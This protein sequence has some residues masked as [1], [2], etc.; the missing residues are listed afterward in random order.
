[1]ANTTITQLPVAISL[2]GSEK[3]EIVQNGTSKQATTLQVGTL[4][5]YLP[6]P[7]NELLG[8]VSGGTA[9]A[10]GVTLTEFLDAT[11]SSTQGSI[12]YRDATGWTALG[13]GTSGFVL[14]T[15][16]PA[17]NPS[18][19]SVGVGS[20]TSISAGTNITASPDPITSI[21]TISVVASPSF[22]DVTITNDLTFNTAGSRI[23]GDF[24]NATFSDRL[25]FQTT[26]ANSTTGIYAL[27]SGSATAASWQATNA[28]DP[29]NASKILIATNASVDVQL[30]SGKNGSGSYL[31]LAFYTNNT[32]R[33]V[34]NTAGAFGIGP[35]ASADYGLSGQAFISG[36]VAAQPT[37]G[38]LSVGGGG[39]G[40]TTF[41][42][43]GVIYGNLTG[44]L[45]VTAA[46]TTGQFLVGNTGAAPT[47]SSTLPSSLAV[48]DLSFGTTGLTPS[49][50]TTGSITVAGTLV[51]ANGGTGQ[52]SYAV[53]DILYAATSSTLAK[54]ADVAVG[55]VLVSGGVGVA[56]AWS[57]APN[58][59]GTL[60]ANY[61]IA[62][63][64]TSGTR[65]QGAFAYG[66][67][68]YSDT[69]ILASF[70][71]SVDSY[72]EIIIQ[73][74]N[75]GTSASTNFIVA[76]DL[77]TS[78]TYFGEFGMNSSNFSGTGS[79]G[80]PNNIYLAATSADLVLATVTANAIRFA[81]N[82]GATD[83]MSINSSSVTNIQS[84]TLS[85][86]LGPTYGG[87]GLSSYTVGDLIYASASNTL[88]KLAD[89]AVGSV[90]VSG[91]IATA[92]S[93][94]SS[95]TISTSVTTPVIIGGTAAGSTLTLQSTSGVGTTDQVIID[96]GNNGSVTAATFASTGAFLTM[97][98]GTTAIAPLKL[99][100]GTN[101]TT[102]AA[103][104]VE[105]DGTNYYA[106]ATTVAGRGII[107][108]IQHFKL[109]ASGSAIG[110]AIAD[111]FGTG[112][113]TSLETNSYY[114]L[115]ADLFFTKTTAGTVT[116]TLTFSNAPQSASAYYVGTPVGGVGTVGNAVT[117]A[118]IN[119]TS[120]AV[121]MPATGSLTTAVNH[122]YKIKA[123][124]RANA[125][126]GGTL[127]VRITSSAGT[128]TPLILSN[129]KVTK[130]PATNTG[131]FA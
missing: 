23:L 130:I 116:F 35:T 52:S 102:A 4:N 58:I 76:N 63:G 84:L 15:G 7:N 95:P 1:M 49:T 37:W 111:F 83:A 105:Y 38:T 92:P 99:T 109:T 47:W 71:S 46:G 73:N 75:S 125:S 39:T 85:T 80:T 72:N 40:A 94:S 96:V 8:N 48:T 20:V 120:T 100:S 78:S 32:G 97:G 62:D 67:V 34:M 123:V 33:F 29:T 45:G 89:V 119:S 106:T 3:I 114:E 98:A 124:F 56:P 14:A 25:S 70:Q 68:S 117:A 122:E 55:S 81:V 22:T 121:A 19:T 129:Y 41:T 10:T 24:S 115:E 53:G 12:L 36:G 107:P 18:W 2:D 31:P 128:V 51:A 90:L 108:V 79:F 43:Y 74:T 44:A 69:N 77:G 57:N 113:G 87:T 82:N 5:I 30:V 65:N 59:D 42:Q 126:T 127:N 13:P 93:Y 6:I 88:S 103:G 110:A 61:L 86:A 50:S 118:V 26:T 27:P 131:A 16:G 11:T 91:G 17:A 112:S 60:T 104:A 21:G 54:L 66:T 28:S 64:A 101:L 9:P